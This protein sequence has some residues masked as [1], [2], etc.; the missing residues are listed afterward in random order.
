M[1]VK[2]VLP[3]LQKLFSLFAVCFCKTFLFLSFP[4]CQLFCQKFCILCLQ[5]QKL[6]SVLGF[7]FQKHF[8]N[9]VFIAKNF[10]HLRENFSVFDFAFSKT[11]LSF[12]F[13]LTFVRKFFVIF[14]WGSVFAENHFYNQVLPFVEKLSSIF[15]L[16]LI[17]KTFYFILFMPF[18]G[19]IFSILDFY[20]V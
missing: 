7:A 15:V 19:K 2:T 18:I 13:V 10:D 14:D 20:F 8:A 1:F 16:L 5:L 3:F 12:V 6:F 11:F 4:V 17:G 9:S